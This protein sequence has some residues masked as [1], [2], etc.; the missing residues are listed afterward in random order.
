MSIGIPMNIRKLV[1]GVA[2]SNCYIV[3]DPVTKESLVID[4]G[5]PD[6]AL[7][8]ACEPLYVKYILVTHRHFDHL[9]GAKALHVETGAPI[10]A[11]ALEACGLSDAQSSLAARFGVELPAAEAGLLLEEGQAL[12]FAGRA[13]DVLH[14]PGHTEGSV[15]FRIDGLLFTGD[16]LM[17][18]GCGTMSLPTGNV[19]QMM[20]SLCRLANLP[21]ELRMLSGHGEESTIAAERATNFYMQAALQSNGDAFV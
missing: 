9:L 20:A 4:P 15:C 19:A 14:T 13:I 6:A 2:H 5:E 11:H 8:R 17:R 16:T 10:A 7:L 1:L 3:T 18:G 12:P 21:G